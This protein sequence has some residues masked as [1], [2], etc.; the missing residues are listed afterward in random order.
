MPC[1]IPERGI[2]KGVGK[3]TGMLL[4]SNNALYTTFCMRNVKIDAFLSDEHNT[5]RDEIRA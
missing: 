3:E 1:L 5:R 4:P 2:S